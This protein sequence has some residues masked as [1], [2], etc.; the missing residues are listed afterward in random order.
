MQTRGSGKSQVLCPTNLTRS[1]ACCV[2]ILDFKDMSGGRERNVCQGVHACMLPAY[3]PNY[4]TISPCL[5]DLALRNAQ[6]PALC[7]PT[8][9]T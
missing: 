1:K 8:Y 7:L 3:L 2:D 4:Y 5:R 9:S 6:P